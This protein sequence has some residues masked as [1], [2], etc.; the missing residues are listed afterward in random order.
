MFPLTKGDLKSDQD[1]K[2]KVTD[3]CHHT[4]KCRGDAN[5]ICNLKFNMPNEVSVVFHNG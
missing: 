4:E 1:A 5:S 3:Y 2:R